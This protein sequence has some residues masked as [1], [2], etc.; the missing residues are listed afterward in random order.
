MVSHPR[1]S[2]KRDDSLK[3]SSIQIETCHESDDD[4]NDKT[5]ES[6]WCDFYDLI[7]LT[8]AIYGLIGVWTTILLSRELA[9]VKLTSGFLNDNYSYAA[10]LFLGINGLME[11]AISALIVFTAFLGKRSRRIIFWTFVALIETTTVL[12]IVALMHSLYI[13]PVPTMRDVSRVVKIKS[14]FA[15]Q[16]SKMDRLQ[17][18]LGCCGYDGPFDYG[19]STLPKSCVDKRSSFIHSSGCIDAIWYYNKDFINACE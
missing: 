17:R 13:D 9:T 8:F 5:E 7:T 15:R 16:E 4:G 6:S 18:S 3:D 10:L 11:V 2:W 14:L 19:N 12:E 1:V